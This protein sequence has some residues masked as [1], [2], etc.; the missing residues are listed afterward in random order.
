MTKTIRI[1]DTGGPEVLSVDDVEVGRPG[2]AQ[3]RVRHTAVGLNFIDT[4]HRSGLY[5]LPELPHGIGIEAAGVVEEVGD[6]VAHLQ[7]GDRVA[8]AGGS[9][10]AAVHWSPS[11]TPRAHPSLSTR[12]SYRAAARSI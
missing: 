2:P 8:Y 1:H 4:Y 12:S 6:E 3:A 11:A 10:G 7:P 9:P 5:P